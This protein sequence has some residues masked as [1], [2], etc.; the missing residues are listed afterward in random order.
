[1]TTDDNGDRRWFEEHKDRS[2]RFRRSSPAELHVGRSTVARAGFT[3]V[4][5]IKPGEYERLLLPPTT[6][7]TPV[8]ELETF[9]ASR[10]E[11][12]CADLWR[13]AIGLDATEENDLSPSET[14][15]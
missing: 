11:G 3:V 13:Y 14:V 5:Q 1:M 12:D 4:R 8:K 2:F 7:K 9:I 10:T 6:A 15:H